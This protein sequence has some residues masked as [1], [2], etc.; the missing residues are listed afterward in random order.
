MISSAEQR[1]SLQNSGSGQ[2]DRFRF[3]NCFKFN[4]KCRI[5]L[6]CKILSWHILLKFSL[7]KKLGQNNPRPGLT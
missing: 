2:F 3:L 7:S 6:I 5:C 1:K 4:R